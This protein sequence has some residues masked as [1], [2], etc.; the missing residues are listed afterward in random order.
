MNLND[1]LILVINLDRAPQRLAKITRQ[2]DELGLPWERLSAVDGQLLS[3]EDPVLLDIQGFGLR[4]GKTPLPGELGCYVSH[5]RAFERFESSGA[6][7]CLILEDDV[8]LHPDLPA[9]LQALADHPEDWD[10]VKLS[11]VHH[12]S[13]VTTARFD[14]GVR[15]VSMLSK[16]TGSSAYVINRH[17]VKRMAS[18]LLPM[19]LPFDHEY[20]RGWFWGVKVCSLLPYVC[21]HDQQVASTINTPQDR[22][23]RFH[24]VRRLPAFAWR[25]GNA[26]QRLVYGLRAWVRS[27]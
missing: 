11:G 20:D 6:R 4:H 23:M 1:F 15:L 2:L 3:M 18:R 24:W 27:F 10:L 22:N 25:L 7:Y 14:M 19:R 12:G 5:V 16:C 9:A 21:L 13:P 17:A 26:S 8:E